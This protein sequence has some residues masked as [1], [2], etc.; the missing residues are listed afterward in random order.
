MLLT[1]LKKEFLEHVLSLRFVVASV[2]SLALVTLSLIVLKADYVQKKEAFDLNRETYRKEAERLGSYQQLQMEGIHVDRPPAKLQVSYY[3]LEKLEDKTSQVM[4]FMAP[5]PK[6]E[7]YKSPASALFPTPDILY[8]VATVLSLMAFVF[9]YDAVCGERES[10]TMRLVL[11]YS[12]P[13]DRFILAKWLGGYLSLAMPFVIALVVAA[14]IILVSRSVGF[15]GNQ[16]AAYVLA[17]LGS[18]LFIAVMFSLGMFVS[19]RCARPSTAIMI[20]LFMWVGMV[21][22]VPN[23]SPYVS[24][25]VKRVTPSAVLESRML[26]EVGDIVREFTQK[27][28]QMGRKYEPQFREGEEAAQQAMIAFGEEMGTAFKELQK[29]TNMVTERNIRNFE[30]ELNGQIEIAKT[31]SRLS[32]VSSYVYIATDVAG[33]G[34]RKQ[35]HF[36]EAL[37]EYQT[38][39]RG[40]INRKTQGSFSWFKDDEGEGSYDISDMPVFNYVEEPIRAR[41]AGSLLDFGLLGV[42]ALFFFMAA[43]VSFL[44]A[45]VI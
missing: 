28:E 24:N 9:S 4:V 32:P 22:F 29:N 40:Y 36:M 16:W 1:L 20:L 25:Q 45:D 23:V 12:V 18:L 11:S 21:L 31:I 8:V 17:A 39:F 10:G 34:V 33:T 6:A 14:L 13:R 43:F 44:R 15:T 37:R 27:M 26:Q 7:L 30:N 3:G 2:L 41:V 5:Y 35:L 42:E 19:S 38:A